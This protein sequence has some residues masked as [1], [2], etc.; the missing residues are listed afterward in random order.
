M[1]EEELKD[2]LNVTDDNVGPLMDKIAKI[3]NISNHLTNGAL[4]PPRHYRTHP[5]RCLTSSVNSANSSQPIESRPSSWTRSLP[6]QHQVPAVSAI[7]R[8]RL[9]RQSCPLA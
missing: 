9:S 8:T 7:V 4:P 2:K 1:T 5:H 3:K 6:H